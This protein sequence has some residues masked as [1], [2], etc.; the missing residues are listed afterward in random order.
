MRR[1]ARH[2]GP[3]ELNFKVS[4]G[5]VDGHCISNMS[6]EFDSVSKLM[7]EMQS[8]MSSAFKAIIQSMRLHMAVVKSRASGKRWTCGCRIHNVQPE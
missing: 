2:A 1:H 7:S 3:A 8:M 4:R 5:A 6:S